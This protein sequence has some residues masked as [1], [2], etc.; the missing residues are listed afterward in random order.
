GERSEQYEVLTHRRDGSDVWVEVNSRLV[1]PSDG[2]PFIQGIARDVTE[3]KRVEDALRRSESRYRVLAANIFDVVSETDTQGRVSFMTEN[4]E[5]LLGYT[6]AEF[7]GDLFVD[8][9]HPDDRDDVIAAY[10]RTLEGSV[11]ERQA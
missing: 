11:S 2:P 1:R 7:V 5:Q 6:P 8:Y 10:G 9:V 3:R 4:V